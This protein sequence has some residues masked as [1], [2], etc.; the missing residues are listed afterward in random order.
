ME[1]EKKIILTVDTGQSEKT[2]KSLKKDI[3]DLKDAILN[4]E[5]GTDEYN[6]AVEQ[7]QTAQRELN[8]VQSL[9]KKTAVA[10]EGSYDALTHQMSL[11][12]KEWR[13]TADES[14]RAELGKQIDEINQQ[15]KEMDAS[16]GNY[17][18]NVGNYVS[19]W[20]GAPDVFAALK[21]EIKDTKNE[22]LQL[23]E[24]TEEYNNALA[25]LGNAQH[26]LRD[27][28]E[29]SKYATADLGEQL[30]N[31]TGIASG[32]VAGF[33]ALQ[34]VMVLCGAEGE[35]LQQTM[36]KLQAAMAVVQGMKGLEGLGKR[37]KGLSIAFKA[38]TG[39][40][41]GWVTVIVALTTVVSLLIKNLP[42]VKKREEE[43]TRQIE[44]AK[45]A[46]DNLR[47]S[48]EKGNERL[49]K[50]IELLKAQGVAEKELLE[51]QAASAKA[52]KEITEKNYRETLAAQKRML[53]MSEVMTAGAFKQVYGMNK[54][55]AKE[56][57]AEL[58]ATAKETYEQAAGAYED[59]VHKM[60]VLNEQEETAFKNRLK[61][62]EEALKDEETKLREQYERDLADA[63]KYGL[64]KTVIEEKYQA[65][66]KALKEKYKKEETTVIKEETKS[67]IEGVNE[68]L[69]AEKKA[70]E[71]K[72]D[73]LDIE[74]TKEIAKA[75]ETITNKENL[76]KEL[77]RIDNDYAE[78]EHNVELELLKNKLAILNQ[79]KDSTELTEQERL[80][81]QEEIAVTELEMEQAKWDRKKEIAIQANKEIQENL[82]K[83]PAPPE[84]P[85]EIKNL[86]DYWDSFTKSL[87][88][89]DEQW[90]SM[91]LKDKVDTVTNL[92]EAT[93]G[94]ASQ[95]MNSLADMYE[96]EEHLGEEEMKKIKNLRI[97]GATIDMLNGAVTAFSSAMSLGVP[98]GPIVGAANAASVISMGTMNI[99]KIRN[100][101]VDGSVNYAAGS[102]VM[103]NIGT[104]T[105][106]LPVNYTRN[107]TTASET[108]ELNKATK[109]YVLE[110]D[111]AEAMNKVSVRESESSF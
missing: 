67:V 8:E 37:I 54:K 46:Q 11:L 27:M 26:Q 18:R 3:S 111:I 60:E 68:K 61:Q 24:D 88:G 105:T 39:I 45:T 100:T 87:T 93:F 75:Y 84:Q 6:D 69:S 42:I 5:K 70:T 29:S 99:S 106:E 34:G 103:P 58:V 9:T 82:Q 83:N 65:D 81:I 95:I 25:R 32:V 107:V 51:K 50:R 63:E 62:Y 30:D 57:Y 71:R 101:K 74:K 28:T 12:K 94:N 31:V 10:L 40:S 86:K 109:V 59:Y 16:I 2:V 77:E 55:N 102:S 72:L 97:A 33:S 92:T 98:L 41:A 7:L 90:N 1:Q 15:L 21:K 23:E 44:R 76:E 56:H 48:I 49:N 19:H 17:G 96:S 80:D 43:W 78:K 53:E 64:D 108:E 73:L 104:Y 89:F 14:R 20:E 13:A 52:D 22:L 66:L 38:I 79:W 47:E 36:V 4:L 91:N 35:N 85:A 110:S